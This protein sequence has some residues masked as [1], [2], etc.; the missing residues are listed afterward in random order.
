MRHSQS[1]Q[2]THHT[3]HITLNSQQVIGYL[4]Y[5]TNGTI[6]PVKITSTGTSFIFAA[7]RDTRSFFAAIPFPRAGV[8]EHDVTASHGRLPAA[9]YDAMTGGIKTENLFGGQ[10]PFSSSFNERNRQRSNHPC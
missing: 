1:S 5:R 6:A 8:G 3:S 2:L 7:L 10:K 4:H 9:E